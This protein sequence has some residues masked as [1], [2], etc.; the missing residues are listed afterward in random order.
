MY[1]ASREQSLTAAS[2]GAEAARNGAAERGTSYRGPMSMDIKEGLAAGPSAPVVAAI[3]AGEDSYGYAILRRVRELS[4]DSIEWTDGMLYPALHRLERLGYIEARWEAAPAGRRRKYYRLTPPGRARLV[5]ARRQWPGLDARDSAPR[6]VLL[7]LAVPAAAP[8]FESVD[9]AALAALREALPLSKR[10]EYAGCIYRLDGEYHYTEPATSKDRYSYD[11]VF[12]YPAAAEVV[13]FYHTHP[14]AMFDEVFS[15]YDIAA[16]T[17]SGL[18]SYLGVVDSGE[19]KVFR[20]GETPVRKR[21][22]ARVR[23]SLLVSEGQPVGNAEAFA[24]H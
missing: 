7:L 15:P 8:A 13:A 6:L 20:P 14:P 17:E 19:L 5:A 3:L 24:R 9:E 18:P 2:G 23:K 22:I 4:P 21:Y 16:A 11:L 12:R 10:W 1:N